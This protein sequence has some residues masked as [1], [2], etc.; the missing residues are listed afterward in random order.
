[1]IN[2]RSYPTPPPP[3]W[4]PPFPSPVPVPVRPRG[5]GY[6]APIVSAGLSGLSAVAAGTVWFG[7]R[8]RKSMADIN[9]YGAGA[10][11][12]SY[13]WND[14]QGTVDLLLF[15]SVLTAALAV[16]GFVGLTIARRRDR[17][18]PTRDTHVR[19]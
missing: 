11:I 8:A 19:G 2:R 4:Q 6:L 18:D 1:M 15:L 14:H 9:E 5:V 16:A 12:P 7:V 17:R 10:T 13:P 3:A